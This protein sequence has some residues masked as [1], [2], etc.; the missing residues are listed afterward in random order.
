MTFL[1][2]LWLPGQLPS[3]KATELN[4]IEQ[5]VLDAHSIEPWRVVGA[6]GQPPYENGWTSYGDVYGGIQFCKTANGL[7]LFR[8]LAYA[9]TWG[10]YGAFTL[11]EGYRP[12]NYEEQ[13]IGSNVI[14]IRP[15]GMVAPYGSGPYM[16]FSFVFFRAEQ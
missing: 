7:V 11:P 14:Q 2:K 9:G 5:G 15:S 13:N 16:K 4:R 6:A 1:K 8:G 10:G 3:L 12:S